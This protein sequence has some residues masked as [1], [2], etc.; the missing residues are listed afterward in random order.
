M[1]KLFQRGE[2]YTPEP[3]GEASVLLADSRIAKVGSVDARALESLGADYEIVDVHGCYVVPGFIDPHQ[4]LLGGSGEKGFGTQSP[5]FFISEVVP[6]GITT[7]V[8]CLGVD[9]T[10]KTMAGLLAKAKALKEEG[11]NAF[12]W[13]GGYEVPSKPIMSSV[14]DDIMY[15]E[16]VIG[17]GEIAISDL[18]ATAP[19]PREL[20]RLLTDGYIGG[21]LAGKSRRTHFHV[22][23]RDS[24]LAPLRKVL[25]EFDVEPDWIYATHVERSEALMLEAI[26]LAGRGAAVDVDTVEQDLVKWARFYHEHGGDPRQLTASSDAAEN[27]PRVLYEQIR[28]CVLQ[29]GFP[30][31]QALTWVTSNTARILRLPLKGRLECGRKADLVV[32]SRDTLDIVHVIAEGRWMVRDG[33]LV[34]R[35]RFLESSKREIRLTGAV[36][37]TEGEPQWMAALKQ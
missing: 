15:I 3:R 9:A 25:E 26:E 20:A 7:V 27:S 17:A 21:M 14:R 4:H 28:E 19:E 30:L 34:A 6:F 18:R 2:V 37:E 1:L 32:L 8:G 24:R 13:T 5:E 10:M 16:E 12:V 33:T 29:G 35:E 11:L 23:D 31:E 36:R 22:G